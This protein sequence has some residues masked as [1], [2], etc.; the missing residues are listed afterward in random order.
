LSIGPDIKDVLDELGT[1]FIIHYVD[2]ST[3]PGGKL[4]YDTYPEHSSEFIRQFFYTVTLPFTTIIAKGDIIFFNGTFFL[5]TNLTPSLFEDGVVDYTAVLFRCNI[6]GG[7]LQRFSDSPG[8]SSDYTREPNWTNIYTDIYALHTEARF[9]PGLEDFQDVLEVP[10]EK[11][12]LYIS[13]NYDIKVG[14][15]WRLS[16]TQYYKI[17]QISTRRLDNVNIIQLSSDTRL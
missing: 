15:R 4:D 11:D 14:D 10:I 1:T 13:G 12:L 3:A 17:E 5:V 7:I 9:G 16:S 8:F 2:G 6:S